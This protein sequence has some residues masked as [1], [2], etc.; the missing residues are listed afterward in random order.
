M[1]N[2]SLCRKKPAGKNKKQE[3]YTGEYKKQLDQ[4]VRTTF[5]GNTEIKTTNLY[6]NFKSHIFHLCRTCSF[7]HNFLVHLV[8]LPFLILWFIT[9][10]PFLNIEIYVQW[11][12]L[13]QPAWIPLLVLI[14]IMNVWLTFVVVKSKV[15]RNI[16]A[17]FTWIFF[18]LLWIPPDPIY[19][20]PAA[21]I[22]RLIHIIAQG[23][24]S[25]SIPWVIYDT[26][27]YNVYS[28]V[29]KL[30][31]TSREATAPDKEFIAFS[32]EQYRQMR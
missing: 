11:F 21:G 2:C 9:S 5:T 18:L 26:Y 15:I 24:L 10:L 14:G 17:V 29:K 7:K 25:F 31:L 23:F 6:G 3:V 28:Y 8:L 20:I 27:G 13:L 19:F 16:T 1:G 12:S 30:A 4:K 22:L 32:Q